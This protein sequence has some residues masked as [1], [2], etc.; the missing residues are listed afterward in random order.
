MVEFIKGTDT[1]NHI[2][3]SGMN[4][5]RDYNPSSFGRIHPVERHNTDAPILALA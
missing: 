4:L 2:D 5:G 3:I 1:L